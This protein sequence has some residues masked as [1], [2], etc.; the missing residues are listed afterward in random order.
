MERKAKAFLTSTVIYLV[1]LLL[2]AIGVAVWL[3]GNT[4][5]GG[6]LGLFGI[7][8]IAFRFSYTRQER[9]KKAA[10]ESHPEGEGEK[11]NG[12]MD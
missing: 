2:V 5:F 9:K 1:G 8:C 11:K 12:S 7:L 3:D 4:T 6:T 10:R